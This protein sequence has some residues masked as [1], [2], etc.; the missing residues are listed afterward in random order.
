MSMFLFLTHNIDVALYMADNI[1]VMKDGSIIEQ[2]KNA[3]SYTDFRHD[4]SRMLIESLPP[5][6]PLH[7]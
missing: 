4:Y 2:L 3:A 6:S 1:F 5:R 7:R